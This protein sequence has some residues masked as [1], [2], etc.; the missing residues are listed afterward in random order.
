[1]YKYEGKTTQL[2]ETMFISKE[3]IDVITHTSSSLLID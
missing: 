1:M 2:S 3:L